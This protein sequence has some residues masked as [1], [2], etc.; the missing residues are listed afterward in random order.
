[1]GFP[2]TRTWLS[3]LHYSRTREPECCFLSTPHMYTYTHVYVYPL[4]PLNRLPASLLGSSKV[5][6]RFG[7]VM[8]LYVCYFLPISAQAGLR[9]GLC[10]LMLSSLC[11]FPLDY[12]FPTE[13]HP[14]CTCAQV[15]HALAA[16]CSSFIAP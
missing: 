6:S 1:M 7:E 14:A 8:P 16:C 10:H 9:P 5:H 2:D 12:L 4:K 15:C 13:S 11:T 3:T